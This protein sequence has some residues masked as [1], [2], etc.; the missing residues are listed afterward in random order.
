MFRTLKNKFVYITLLLILFSVGTPTTFLILQFRKNFEQRSIVML[1]TTMDVLYNGLI[2]MMMIGNE[3]NIQHIL[4]NLA[5]NNNISHIR[6]FN[7]S[8]L[9]SHSSNRDEAGKNIKEL[10]PGHINFSKLDEKIINMLNNRST[11]S[12]NIPV[13]NE[14]RCYSCHGDAENLAFLDIDTNLTRAETHFFTGS[15]HMVFLGIF[16]IGL[17]GFGFYMFFCHYINKPLQNFRAAMERVRMGD[18]NARLPAEKDDEFGIIQNHFNQM[19][20]ELQESKQHIEELHFEQ[21]K[22]ADKL[23]TL[24]ELA[25]EMA[26]EINNPVGI[27]QSQADYLN[28]EMNE[29][30]GLK[31]YSEEINIILSH[32]DKISKITKNI[33]K[34]SKKLPTDFKTF[35]LLEPLHSA[36][37]ILEPRFRRNGITIKRELPVEPIAIVGDPLQIEQVFTNLFNNAVDAM[38]EEGTLYITVRKPSDRMTE[39]VIR[40]TGT[41]MDAHTLENIFTPFYTTKPGIKGTGLGLYIVKNICKNHKAEISCES[42]RG[43]GS[44]FTIVLGSHTREENSTH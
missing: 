42:T 29:Q 6:I 39:V 11:F 25:A 12:L 35:N 31:R 19:V 33:L 2:N 30:T 16:M 20:S 40:D 8:G 21:L 13:R 43:K 27:I 3:K 32:V 4:D 5:L 22:R 23:V 36:L 24:G 18:L 34:Y 10:S 28:L 9:I 26:H 7:E 14:Q 17:L 41:G 15:L 1:E 44:T 37:E 38:E